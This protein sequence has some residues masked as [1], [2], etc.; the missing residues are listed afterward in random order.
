MSVRIL[1]CS[2]GTFQL[3]KQLSSPGGNFGSLDVFVELCQ[4]FGAAGKNSKYLPGPAPSG[5]L[6]LLL[7]GVDGAL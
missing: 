5:P 1:P 7:S 3:S 2:Q 4:E 6:K